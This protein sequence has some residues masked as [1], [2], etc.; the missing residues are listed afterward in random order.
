MGSPLTVVEGS[1][2]T[3]RL[4][5]SPLSR[6][7]GLV[8]GG[9]SRISGRDSHVELIHP[10][11]YVN[12]YSEKAF[13]LESA[14]WFVEKLRD[15]LVIEDSEGF[16]HWSGQYALVGLSGGTTPRP[17]YTAI[18]QLAKSTVIDWS[19]VLIFLV[20][21]R[22]IPETHPESNTRMIRETLF[23]EASFP[24]KNFIHPNTTL[25]LEEC[26]ADYEAALGSI[27]S[28]SCPT[29]VTLGLGNDGHTASWFPPL[30]DEDCMH[31]NDA[32][33]LVHI[34]HTDT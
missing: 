5:G 18:S 19:K 30:S 23:S 27:L 6:S 16:P 3:P 32:E 4:P 34:T 28:L 26:R 20:D 14:R 33:R 21:E 2:V 9:V 10:P 8:K 22:Y 24:E 31:S 1:P 7:E 25:P 15:T 17:I 29:L 13:V 11:N 12:C